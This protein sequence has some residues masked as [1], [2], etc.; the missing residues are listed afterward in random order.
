MTLYPLQ[1]MLVD[2]WN[3]DSGQTCVVK[4]YRCHLSDFDRCY[5]PGSFLG[6]EF[7]ISFKQMRGMAWLRLKKR[8]EGMRCF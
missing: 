4:L 7:N 1:P 6:V 3:P 2:S 5:R 8:L